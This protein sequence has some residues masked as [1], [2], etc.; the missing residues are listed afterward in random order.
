MRVDLRP[1]EPAAAPTLARLMQLYAYDFS[2]I[3]NTDVSDEGLFATPDPSPYLSSDLWHP[4]FITAKGHIAGFAIISETSRFGNTDAP[5]NVAEFFVLRKYRGAGAGRAAAEAAFAL[6]RGKWEV[7]QV[8]KNSAATAFWRRVI[9]QYTN[10]FF[11]EEI[12]DDE[13]WRGPVQRFDNRHL[14]RR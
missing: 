9:D 10:G 11:E 8:M 3:I 6:F 2:E 1:I 13:R 4:F 12:C 7:R 5:L 14:N